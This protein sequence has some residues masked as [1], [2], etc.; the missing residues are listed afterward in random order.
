M[1]IS[2][3]ML[4][5]ALGSVVLS[6][7]LATGSVFAEDRIAPGYAEDSSA[8]VVTTSSGDCL[9]TGSWTEADAVI[10]GCD[11]IVLNAPVVVTKGA[12]SGLVSAIV[13]PTAALFAFDKADLTDEGKAAIEEY[14]K[15]L[16]PE[17][18]EAYEGIIIGH[19][20]SI[21]DANYNSGLS[22]RRAEAVSA[23]LVST[24]IDPAKLRELGRGETD[25]IASNDTKEGQ[26]ENRRVEIVVIGEPRA[27]DNIKF[28]SV[29]LFPRRS[30]ELTEAG[31]AVLDKN[32]NE[33]KVMLNRSV[34]IEVVGH[35]DD[36]GD[37]AYNMD[38]SEQRAAAVTQYL[39]DAGVD[40]S[41]I[42]A[43]GAGE[44]LPIATNTTEQGRAENR[45]VEV[46]VLGRV[47]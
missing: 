3:K 47:N 30:A 21:G 46:L 41:K 20:D 31:R 1:N 42:V 40:A 16:R 36:V 6:A 23:Y 18:S 9:H 13:I 44:S 8:N 7:V 14:R 45:R 10:V 43:V 37:D 34:F 19:T 12:P 22:M 38:L 29:T 35:T 33:A 25:P 11:G 5:R 24:G 32:V 2:R 27:L 26:A 15:Q 4:S 39:I 17:L 28:P